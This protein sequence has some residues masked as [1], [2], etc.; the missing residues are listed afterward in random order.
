MAKM[1]IKDKDGNILFEGSK[2]SIKRFYASYGQELLASTN[3]RYMLRIPGEEPLDY[4]SVEEV[5]TACLKEK[6]FQG[7]M[8]CNGMTIIVE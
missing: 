1:I 8:L 5:L 7:G 3:P 4:M 6:N 2:R